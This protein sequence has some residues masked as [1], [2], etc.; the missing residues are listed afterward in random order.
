M[1]R[2]GAGDEI[3]S[4]LVV[5]KEGA[6]SR[7]RKIGSLLRFSRTMK[8]ARARRRNLKLT[9]QT[10]SDFYIRRG[11]VLIDPAGR[12]RF[13]NVLHARGWGGST[14]RTRAS[15][16]I[17]SV[18]RRL[19]RVTD[20]FRCAVC[21]RARVRSSPIV[22]PLYIIY[23]LFDPIDVCVWCSLFV[24]IPSLSRTVTAESDKSMWL[25]KYRYKSAGELFKK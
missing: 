9:R 4:Y 2:D 15:S 10:G 8:R 3:R 1:S 14:H 13:D 22:S 12:N 5:Q 11:L 18:C 7:E 23:I 25:Y 17:R 16:T 19:S 21:V 6:L 20:L 24:F